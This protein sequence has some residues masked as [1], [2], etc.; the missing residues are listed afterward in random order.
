MEPLYATR[1]LKKKDI[2]KQTW[3]HPN[4]KKWCCIDFAIIKQ[5]HRRRCL[6]VLVMHGAECNTDHQ[7]SKMKLL[8]RMKK[9]FRR[10][11][12]RHINRRF[13]VVNLQGRSVVEK[14]RSTTVRVQWVAVK[15]AL[16]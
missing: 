8:V 5:S 6:D 4:S 1:G 7:M 10:E 16:C 13:D 14:G 11:R 12:D 3:Q 2:H 9:M 15:S